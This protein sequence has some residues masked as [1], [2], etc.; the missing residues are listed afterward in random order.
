MTHAAAMQLH[1][2]RPESGRRTQKMRHVHLKVW[3]RRAVPDNILWQMAQIPVL[4][5]AKMLQP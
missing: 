2:L 4:R 5:L 1:I 3:L